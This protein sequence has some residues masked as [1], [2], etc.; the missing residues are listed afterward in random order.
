MKHFLF[1]LL[2][3]INLQTSAQFALVESKDGFVNLRESAKSESKSVQKLKNGEVVFVDEI[4]YS[5]E[6]TWLYVKL[7][8][9]RKGYIHKSG[10]KFIHQLNKADSKAINDQSIQLNINQH[11][12]S[13]STQQFD[14]HQ[15]TITYKNQSKKNEND[16]FRIDDKVFWGTDN[17]IPKSAYKNATFRNKSCLITLPTIGLYEPNLKS[18]NMYLNKGHVYIIAQNGDGAGAY[19]VLWEI[20]QNKLIRQLIFLSAS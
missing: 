6:Q 5:T 14:I 9:E 10:L 3:F 1:T 17:S 18:T 19:S 2:V 16:V 13:V 8:T 20:Y 15:H 12:L 11:Q 4:E 7:N